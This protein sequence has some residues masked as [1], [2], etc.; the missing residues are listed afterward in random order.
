MMPNPLVDA[1]FQFAHATINFSEAD[2][3]QSYAWR[4][5]NE[6]VRFAFIG[7]YHELRDTAVR[8]A[9]Q[10]AQTKQS[11]T[12]AHRALAQ[13][14]EAYRDLQAVM[15]DVNE[16]NYDSIPAPGEWPMRIVFGH[17]VSTQTF[18]FT[19]VHYGLERQRSAEERPLSLPDDALERVIGPRSEFL[20][21]LEN[22]RYADMCAFYE[23]LHQRTM[24]EFATI[25][26]D[27]IMGATLWWEEEELSLLYRLQRF[28]AHLRQHTIQAEKTMARI[29]HP[30]S[31][32]KQLLR[33]IFQA[34]AEVEAARIGAPQLGEAILDELAQAILT[35]AAE[36]VD[37]VRKCREMETAVIQG[38]SVTLETILKDNPELV[39][40]I[41][42]KRLPL[43]LTAQYHSQP[44]IVD[45]LV[46]AGAEL[47]IFEAAAIGR[48]DVVK[49]ELEEYPEDLNENGRDGFTPLQLACFFGQEE[50]VSFLIVQEAEINAKAKNPTQLQAIHA[51]AA[52]GNLN[53]LRQLLENGADANARQQKGFTPLHTAADN[54]SPD[55][56]QLLIQF[57]AD[58][59]IADDSDQTPA[60]LAQEKGY[61]QLLPI[62]KP[63]S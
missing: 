30:P 14:L 35:R 61:D 56:A 54:N 32:S 10:R 43:V 5:H 6:G 2:L 53:I 36:A 38:D 3:D 45:M 23:K 25:T 13:Y 34:L 50:I 11:V 26:D 42:Q 37:I 57:G 58:P 44:A 7:T 49:R 21:I 59:T 1:V 24:T 51:A 62:L 52:N 63:S 40:T 39:D 19:L 12:L 46:N 9:H 16:K 28:D 18:F 55:M 33:L 48:L 27:E 17:S 20:N 47:S 4:A 8:L 29:G 22:G 31:E 60:H 15:L 41:D